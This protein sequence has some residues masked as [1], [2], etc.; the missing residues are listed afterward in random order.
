MPEEMVNLYN[1]KGNIQYD[2]KNYKQAIILYSQAIEHYEEFTAQGRQISSTLFFQ[3]LSNRRNA[4][5]AEGKFER[6]ES[7]FQRA[8]EIKYDRELTAYTLQGK[9]K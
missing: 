9:L 1:S 7:D 2:K 8:S 3:I 5:Q 4:Y 6:A